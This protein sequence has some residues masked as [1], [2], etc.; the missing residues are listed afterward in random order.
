MGNLFNGAGCAFTLLR[1]YAF[2]D[3]EKT[4][5]I[6]FVKFVEKVWEISL[7][8]FFVLFYLTMIALVVKLVLLFL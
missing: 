3:Q 7:K 4:D 5:T 2:Q 8:A 1:L 6:M